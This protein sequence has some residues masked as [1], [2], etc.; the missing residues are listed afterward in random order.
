MFALR[1]SDVLV[2][3]GQLLF[4]RSDDQVLTT[5]VFGR[6]REV[7][8]GLLCV[9]VGVLF[10]L[11]ITPGP[12]PARRRSRHRFRLAGLWPCPLPLAAGSAPSG[13]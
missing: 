9:G 13:C 11:D 3:D 10:A 8:R 5:I 1:L 12:R 4:Q 6:R 2:G 7:F